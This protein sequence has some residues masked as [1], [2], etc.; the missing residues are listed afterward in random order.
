MLTDHD[1]QMALARQLQAERTPISAPK[2]RNRGRGRAR[3]TSHSETN[4]YGTHNST[5]TRVGMTPFATQSS[6]APGSQQ[7][8]RRGL[9]TPT[10]TRENPTVA[11]TARIGGGGLSTSRWAS[12]PY[13]EHVA[14]QKSV[15]GKYKC[16]FS[17]LKLL[18]RYSG[19]PN[20]LAT[21]TCL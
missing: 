6:A 21:L 18:T 13:P 12:L 1:E 5:A 3:E 2:P 16:I 17:L 15:P 10:T 7:P 19:S 9:S 8:S 11:P 14:S 4:F 20:Y